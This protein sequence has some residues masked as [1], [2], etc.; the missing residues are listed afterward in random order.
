L[1]ELQIPISGNDGSSHLKEIP[2]K[3]VA[4]QQF[5]TSAK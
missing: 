4:M 1:F 5:I 2:A 3:K